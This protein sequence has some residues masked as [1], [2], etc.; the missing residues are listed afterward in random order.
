MHERSWVGPRR[1]IHDPCTTVAPWATIDQY[2]IIRRL[3]QQACVT[4][5]HAHARTPSGP[6]KHSVCHGY[7][8]KKEEYH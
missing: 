1:N 6:Q 8:E 7:D 5:Q 2:L 4:L 3:A